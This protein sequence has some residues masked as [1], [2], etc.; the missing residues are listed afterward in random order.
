[1]QAN[2]NKA[3]SG[4]G[5]AATKAGAPAEPAQAGKSAGDTVQIS[6]QAQSL[7][8]IQSQVG[9]EAPVN[10]EKVEALKAAISNG[11]YKVDAHAIAKNM[12]ENDSLF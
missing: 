10:R 6:A 11:T 8:R 4:Q 7:N 12:L 2:A 3:K 1:N 9:K 5:V